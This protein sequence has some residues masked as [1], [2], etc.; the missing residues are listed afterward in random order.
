MDD[1]FDRFVLY[2]CAFTVKRK[3]VHPTQLKKEP[4]S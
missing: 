2:N 1:C 4:K 3:Y